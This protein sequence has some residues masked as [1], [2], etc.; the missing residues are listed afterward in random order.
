MIQELRWQISSGQ[1]T[2][3]ALRTFFESHHND[4]SRRFQEC[5]IQCEQENF[6]SPKWPSPY[7]EA[8]FDLLMRGRRGEPILAVLE[9]LYEEVEHAADLELQ[10]HLSQLPFL[11]LLPLLFLQFPAFLLLL[12]GPVLRHLQSSMGGG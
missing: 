6:R 9:Q 4:L 1:S 3:E 11:A 12:L 8:L 10:R 7:Q 5:W 2:R